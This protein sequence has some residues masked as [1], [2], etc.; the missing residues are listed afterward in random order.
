MEADPLTPTLASEISSI[1]LKPESALAV[2]HARRGDGT[3]LSLV[4]DFLHGD[5]PGYMEESP[6][7][8]FAR[9]VATPNHET[10]QMIRKFSA[11]GQRLVIGQDSGDKFV[12]V[13]HMKRVLG[14]LPVLVGVSE[15]DGKRHE[16]FKKYTIVDFEKADGRPIREVE[17]LWGEPLM[18]FHNR[19]L[20]MVPDLNFELYD[21]SEW[22]DRQGRGHIN[23]LYER[24]FAL[25]VAHAVLI[26][27][28]FVHDPHEAQFVES[29]LLPTL[30]ACQKRFGVSPMCVDLYPEKQSDDYWFGYPKEFGEI[31]ERELEK[32]K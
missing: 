6:S 15:K 7:F 13:N 32:L 27:G 26:E 8:Y 16:V 20:R 31:I 4:K 10:I 23:T 12:S 22:I 11:G 18:E 25:F 5:I 28:Y 9:H 1:F 17:T 29:V 24:Q 14:R 30:S 3:L 21:D 19:L 2:M